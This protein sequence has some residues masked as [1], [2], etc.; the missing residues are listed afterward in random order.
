MSK[1]SSKSST[2]VA[3]A[4]AGALIGATALCS[5]ALSAELALK[6]AVLGAGGVGYFE[7]AAEVDGDETITWRARID[8]V[9]DILKS[10]VVMD[11]AG[12]AAVTLPGK[13]SMQTAFASLPFGETDVA[14]LPSLI[15]ALQGAEI[16]ID[17]PRKLKGRIVN[18]VPEIEKDKDGKV[19]NTR[20]R[21]SIIENGKIDQF[22]LEE[23]EGLTFADKALGEQVVTALNAVRANRDRSGRDIAIRLA[24]GGKRTVRVGMVTEAPVW[25]AAYRLSLPKKG[26]TKG[27]LQGWVVLE[28]MTG[29]AWKDVNVTL[30]AA[31]PVTFRQSLYQPYYVARQDTAPTVNRAAIPVTNRGD[32]LMQGAVASA[33]PPPA[34]PVV[35]PPNKAKAEA[36][37]FSG[38]GSFDEYNSA[39]VKEPLP[40]LGSAANSAD[41]VENI[42]GSSFTLSMPVSVGAGESMTMP[43]IDLPVE[44][45]AVAWYQGSRYQTNVSQRNP[46]HAVSV[47][48]GSQTTLPPGVVT[49]YE[50]TVAGPLFSGDAQLSVLPVGES[51][52]LGFGADQKVVVDKD[53]EQSGRVV[54]LSAAK[55]VLTVERQDRISTVYRVKNVSDQARTLVLEHPRTE[56]WNLKE[57][58]KDKAALTATAYRIRFEVPAGETKAM[59]VT[60]ERPVQETMEIGSIDGDWVMAFLSQPGIDAATRA[61]L[62]PI[63]DLAAKVADWDEKIETLASQK[64]EIVEDQ[65][66]LRDNLRSVP[67]GS[68]LSRLYSQKLLEQEKSLDN[69]NA[70]TVKAK[71]ELEAVRKTLADAIAKL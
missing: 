35:V 1:K 18:A 29:N 54:K 63:A 26:E 7:Y 52:L 58:E 14:R 59:T 22:I 55:G 64:A 50:D 37:R 10:M 30:S 68:D 23:A 6:R 34:M 69:L 17:A 56:G 41:G 39:A 67:N 28:N 71:T 31:A 19:L 42:A 12:P 11:D 5:P 25:K 38:G 51:R 20:T 21:V 53:T 65:G 47:K 43:F 33:P 27:R 13:A 24:K 2:H 32:V 15:A 62:A 60:L 44:A 57:P 16:S 70:G 40:S 8:Q 4:L 61:K 66:R 9:D 49:L 3:K 45:D 36:F 48:N 46:W